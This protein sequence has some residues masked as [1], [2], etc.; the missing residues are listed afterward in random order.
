MTLLTVQ[1]LRLE[2]ARRIL[3]DELELET[4]KLSNSKSSD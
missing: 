2:L 3:H 4:L 1:R